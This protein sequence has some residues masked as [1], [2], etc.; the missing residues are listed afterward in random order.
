[1]LLLCVTEKYGCYSTVCLSFLFAPYP[2]SLTVF[3]V[4]KAYT[5]HA[6]TQKKNLM[7]GKQI[8]HTWKQYSA[9]KEKRPPITCPHTSHSYTKPLMKSLIKFNCEYQRTNRRKQTENK[10]SILQGQNLLLGS[11]YAL[12]TATDGTDESKRPLVTKGMSLLKFVV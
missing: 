2:G 9:N 1:M 8:Q 6:L 12:P 3:A 5:A 10:L 7:T 4:R 11:T